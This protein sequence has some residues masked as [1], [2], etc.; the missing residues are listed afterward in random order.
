[1]EGGN[2]LHTQVEHFQK[3][4]L[5]MD[6]HANLLSSSVRPTSLCTT[7]Q[8]KVSARA[9]ASSSL[10]HA[11]VN[12]AEARGLSCGVGAF[13]PRRPARDA[14][15]KKGCSTA[16]F[17]EENMRGQTHTREAPR[18]ERSQLSARMEL[19]IVMSALATSVP[20]VG[21]L[22]CEHNKCLATSG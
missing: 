21:A 7:S 6:D 3:A 17:N 8:P 22:L 20:F 9:T 14:A 10:L 1:M 16:T 19:A 18:T 4:H 5:K 13:A 15:F 11:S 2:I 12:D